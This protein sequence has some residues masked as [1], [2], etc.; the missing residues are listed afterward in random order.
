MFSIETLLRTTLHT[1]EEQSLCLCLVHI[2]MLFSFF[3]AQFGILLL[4][5]KTKKSIKCATHMINK[6]KT[7]QK[8]NSKYF[9]TQITKSQSQRFIFIYSLRIVQ[10]RNVPFF[11]FFCSVRILFFCALYRFV[12]TISMMLSR[13]KKNKQKNSKTNHAVGTKK[14]CKLSDLLN[15]YSLVMVLYYSKIIHTPSENHILFMLVFFLPCQTPTNSITCEL[16]N[17]IATNISKCVYFQKK[18]QKI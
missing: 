6:E 11:L 17:F 12:L 5:V 15:R 14:I 3:N 7:N 10:K 16:N 9:G 1:I 13:E 18:K 4:C 2:R 8:K